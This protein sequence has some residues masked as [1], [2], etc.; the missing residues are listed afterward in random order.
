[1]TAEFPVATPTTL[2]LPRGWQGWLLLN[3]GI[4]AIYSLA[5]L[6]VFYV[7]IGA[8]DISPIFPPSG[9]AVASVLIFGPRIWPALWFGNFCNG[10]PLFFSAETSLVAAFIG[11]AAGGVA[12]VVEALCAGRLMRWLSGNWQPFDRARDTVVFLLIAALGA[13]AS[14]AIIG[15]GT[16]WLVGVTPTDQF[17]ITFVTWLLADAAGIGVFA[18]LVLAW[19]RDWPGFDS[20]VIGTIA[21]VAGAV[22]GVGALAYITKYPIDYL[23]LPILLWAGFRGKARGASFAAVAISAVIIVATAHGVGSFIGKSDNQ[24]FLLVEGFMAVISF[25]GLLVVAV[26]AQ[27]EAAELAL[28]AHN[29]TLEQRVVERT[30]EIAEKNRLL[31][32]KDQRINDDLIVARRL[33]AAILPTDFDSFAP[34]DV[35]AVMRPAYEMAGDFYDVF[36]IGDHRLALI[37]GDVSG[38]GIAAAFFMA[39]AR[40]TLHNIAIRGG[41][42]PAECIAGVNETLCSENPLDM[43]VTLF[44][45]EFDEVTGEVAYI[46][47]GH[48]EPVIVGNGGVRLLK[49]TGDPVLGIVPGRRFAEKRVTLAADETLFL[50]TDGVTEAFDPAGSLYE[51]KRLIAVAEAEASKSPHELMLAVIRSVDAFAQGTL[52]SDDITCL[53]V[54]RGAV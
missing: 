7:G 17:P 20:R 43:F 3:L 16:F 1:V 15:V 50:Y 5:G 28:E 13:A 18:P 52:Q 40:T 51:V 32:E 11:N 12:A 19:Y 8:A 41:L 27:Q 49:R 45:A 22:L 29:R 48:C 46:N 39:V 14:A 23:Y 9:I 6:V 35:A 34:T 36:R 44:Y 4:F 21:A 31:E 26:R 54:R 53:A 37:V 10:A 47:A 25:T 42:A 38:K 24:S 33:Q 30:A 2:G